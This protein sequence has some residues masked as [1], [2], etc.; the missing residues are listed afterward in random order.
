M[1]SIALGMDATIFVM[2]HV[3]YMAGVALAAGLRPGPSG[4]VAA[5][6]GAASGT[7]FWVYAG[8]SAIRVWRHWRGKP[9]P[10]RIVTPT[11]RLLVRLRRR[12]ALVGIALLTPVL[13]SMPVGCALALSVEPRR[14]KV[15]LAVWASVLAWSVTLFGARTFLPE[16]GDFLLGRPPPE[17][18][19]AP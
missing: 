12:K 17:L 9:R 19:D 10:R 14:R 11:R 8:R 15:V 7:L 2:S 6:L 1:E 3:K 5:G 13:L 18:V 4:F 16:V